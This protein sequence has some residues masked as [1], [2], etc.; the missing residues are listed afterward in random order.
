MA[1][2]QDTAPAANPAKITGNR[3]RYLRGLDLADR[4]VSEYGYAERPAR[5]G[6]NL[7]HIPSC[8]AE[9]RYKV[10]VSAG[11]CEC[12][13]FRRGHTMCK[14]LVAGMIL[15]S[16][17][18][19]RMAHIVQCGGCSARTPYG[20]THEVTDEHVEWGSA[21]FEG[22]LICGECARRAGVS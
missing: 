17:R 21:F 9:R 10:D 18:R 2:K 6:E 14:H 1:T 8:T 7:Y 16:R 19:A 12:E 3:G 5:V 4:K 11:T 22:D 20:E 13:D 15:E